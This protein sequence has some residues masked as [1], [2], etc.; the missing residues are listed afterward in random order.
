MKINSFVDLIERFKKNK[1]KMK[2]ISSG[3]LEFAF[4]TEWEDLKIGIFDYGYPNTG[5]NGKILVEH[6]ENFDKWSKVFYDCNFPANEEDFKVFLE[7]LK[8]IGRKFN[9]KQGNNFGGLS[10]SF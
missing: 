5:Y 9:E 10:R 3:P 2:D 7:D 4:Y 8:Y 1:F 6:K